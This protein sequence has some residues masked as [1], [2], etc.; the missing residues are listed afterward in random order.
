MDMLCKLIGQVDQLSNQ[1]SNGTIKWDDVFV[2]HA[3]CT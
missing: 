2:Q 1:D 3:W